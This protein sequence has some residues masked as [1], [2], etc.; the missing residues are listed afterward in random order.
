MMATEE[1]KVQCSVCMGYDA[2]V[3]Y[4]EQR[5]GT[6]MFYEHGDKKICKA[7]KVTFGLPLARG[8]A[9]HHDSYLYKK[10]RPI[11]SLPKD[12]LCKDCKKLLVIGKNTTVHLMQLYFYRCKDC[13]DKRLQSKNGR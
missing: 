13:E 3:Y 4:V 9:K 6:Y 8:L 7:G 10:A 1:I 2:R 12:K 5:D 11:E